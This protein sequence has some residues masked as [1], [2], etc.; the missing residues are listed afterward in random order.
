M[1][2]RHILLVVMTLALGACGVEAEFGDHDTYQVWRALQAAAEHPDYNH[3]DYTKRW[4]VMENI[5]HVDDVDRRIDIERRLERVL[6]RP[7][8]NPLH[9][10]ETWHFQI[11]LLP[12][13]G[14]LVHFDNMGPAVP[15]HLQFEAER[16]FAEVRRFLAGFPPPQE[17]RDRMRSDPDSDSEEGS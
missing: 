12:G 6:H 17:I 11:T 3:Q 8:T 13:P 9:Q 16:Y 14:N 10:N 4:T 1:F 15:T 5:V 2:L 7:R